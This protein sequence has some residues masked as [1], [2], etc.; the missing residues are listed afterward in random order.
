MR[1]YE[2]KANPQYS[3]PIFETW[4]PAEEIEMIARAYGLIL[5]VPW[6][7]FI[8]GAA[9]LK[10]KASGTKKLKAKIELKKHEI[11]EFDCFNR[12]IKVD[13]KEVSNEILSVDSKLSIA[14]STRKD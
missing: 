9:R 11:T 4:V 1:G 14:L 3:V 6:P 5:P 10:G 2:F 8:T 12:R 13:N 7:T